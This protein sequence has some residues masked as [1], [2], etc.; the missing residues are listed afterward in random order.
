MGH[1]DH[2]ANRRNAGCPCSVRRTEWTKT[3][4]AGPG[5]IGQDRV[6]GSNGGATVTYSPAEIL[7]SAIL[8]VALAC[9]IVGIGANNKNEI[10]TN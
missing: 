4:R 5:A 1:L 6:Q 2:D 9:M 3:A 8:V 10:N 7:V